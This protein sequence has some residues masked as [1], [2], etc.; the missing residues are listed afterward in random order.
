ML[1]DALGELENHGAEGRLRGG[2]LRLCSCRGCR[3]GVGRLLTVKGDVGGQRGGRH[4]C[5]ASEGEDGA[6]TR[7]IACRARL[8]SRESRTKSGCRIFALR[9]SPDILA[10]SRTFVE[11][12]RI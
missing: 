4:V 2:G 7:L 11:I 5:R 1:S 9:G 3:G 8:L 12:R 10:L 6:S